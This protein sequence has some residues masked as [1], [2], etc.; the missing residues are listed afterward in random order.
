MTPRPLTVVDIFC[1]AGGLS[2]GFEDAVA[3]WP[4]HR[5]EK[6]EIVYGTD[7]DEDAI[8]TFRAFHFPN[9][10]QE[11][12]DVVTPCKD[13]KDITA[14]SI[15]E[16]IRPRER[17]DVLIG[18]PNCQGVSAAGLRNPDDCRNDMLLAFIR[19]VRELQPQWFIMEN[20]PGL[21]HAN[22][23]DLL[24]AIFE[25][26]ES[27]KGYK[28]S[29]DVLLAADYGVPQFR[30]RLFVVGTNTGAPIRF[31]L[32]T[33]TP[34]LPHR[35]EQSVETECS[36]RT[37]KQEIFDLT[38]YSPVIYDR[39][40]LPNRSSRS[41]SCPPNHYC[42]ELGKTNKERIAAIEP[43]QD[44]RD[45]P[46]RLLPERYF[47]TRASDQKGAYGRLLWDWPAYTITNAAYNVT[48]GPFTHPDHDR[49]LSVR[50]A[51]RLQSFS[52]EHVFYGNVLSQYRQVGNA[53]PPKLA[54]AVAE[55]I[56][57]CHYRR[58]EAKEWGEEGRLN[59]E[60]I[61]DALDGTT[62]FPTMTPRSVHP[63][64]DRRRRR[65]LVKHAPSEANAGSHE[66]AWDAEPRPSDP[67]P[68]DTRRLRELAKQ[69][70]NY[71]A[72]KRARAII[73]FIDNKPKEDI[74][75]NANV[76]EANVKKWVDGYFAHGLDGWR[77]Y[78]TPPARI[79][80]YD[81][82]LTERIRKA[83]KRVRRINLSPSKNGTGFD[84]NPKRLH[85]NGYLLK[86]IGSFGDFSV[87]GLIEEVE[88]K[89]ENGVGTVYV[90]DL[91]A[92]C[93]VVLEK[94]TDGEE[95]EKKA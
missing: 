41:I 74:V 93:D 80:G 29:G 53:V 66:S 2:A 14:E 31:P 56:L 36:Y 39:K 84:T 9:V 34:S 88:K 76:A 79:A 42:I 35:A 49:A 45:M 3:W 72:A 28:V 60:L 12:L 58:E 78:H 87:N 19:L 55:A 59:L 65:K 63:L 15:L 11:R 62:S 1:G 20:V 68:E 27:I 91:L 89:L 26:F 48:A 64:F 5:G 38:H 4:N 6:F 40:V 82:I 17:V 24:A 23:R 52:D 8:E 81:P 67:Y 94:L 71:R 51:A 70:G 92:I 83:I 43:G 13:I 25:Q 16:A 61:R 10:Q 22:N 57:Y 86:L 85:M 73:E 69:P 46:M 18:G 95:G 32:A 90:G 47:A 30:Y 7:C 37:V 44:W 50:E 21:T 54:K 77:A 75:K 33:R